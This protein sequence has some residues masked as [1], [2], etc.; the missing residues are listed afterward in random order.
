M[1]ILTNIGIDLVKPGLGLPKIYAKQADIG[2]GILVTVYANGSVCEFTTETINIYIK[3]PDGLMIY[4]ACTVQDGKIKAIFTSQALA[5]PG[6]A[7]VELEIISQSERLSTPIAVMEIQPSNIDSDAIESSNE[8]TALTQALQQV[9]E[10]TTAANQAAQAANTAASAANSA[11]SSANEA[12]GSVT[13]AKEAAESAASAANTAAGS[14]NTAAESANTSAGQANTAAGN[15]NSAAQAANTAATNA[16]NAVA[17]IGDVN[18]LETTDK[19]NL[20]AAINELNDDLD[21]LGNIQLNASGSNSNVQING[22]ANR[23]LYVIVVYVGDKYFQVLHMGD[24]SQTNS[25][26]IVYGN[27]QLT[28][29]WFNVSS[30]G[31]ISFVQSWSTNGGWISS[32]T[33]SISVYQIMGIT[34][35]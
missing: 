23:Q 10:S 33:Y 12:A 9:M 7:Q 25:H 20:V 18:D 32:P 1:I 34:A 4:N 8:F 35:K 13:E 30:S 14:A 19:S 26:Y 22:Y 2:R 17:S 31:N 28:Y 11:A 6:T 21:G 16:N 24:T 15:A 27:G 3:K 5:A 29:F